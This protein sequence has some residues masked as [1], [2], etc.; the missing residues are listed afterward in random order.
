MFR[1]EV[2]QAVWNERGL[3]EIKHNYHSMR[4]LTETKLSFSIKCFQLELN[5]WFEVLNFKVVFHGQYNHKIGILEEE[6]TQTPFISRI[7]F[8]DGEA[9][10]LK[11]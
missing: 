9:K 7:H 11:V 8:M 1:A 6:K 5:N 4:R 2:L 3:L 10:A